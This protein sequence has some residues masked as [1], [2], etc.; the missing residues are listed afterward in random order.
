MSTSLAPREYSTDA[1][2]ISAPT[3]E[4]T[5]EITDSSEEGSDSFDLIVRRGTVEERHPNLTTKRTAQNF[6]TVVN[7]ESKL[8]EIKELGRL[9][10]AERR[11]AAGLVALAGSK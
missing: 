2:A 7:A 11:P 6:V 3:D 9:A 8:V 5:V 1:E 4:V 10:A